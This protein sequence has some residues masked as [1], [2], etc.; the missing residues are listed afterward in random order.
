M[1]HRS[2]DINI[3][4]VSILGDIMDLCSIFML[5]SIATESQWE[6]KNKTLLLIKRLLQI[7]AKPSNLIEPLV[8]HIVKT[9]IPH[10]T[11]KLRDKNRNSNKLFC[12]FSRY[13]KDCLRHSLLNVFVESLEESSNS[14][15]EKGEE[16]KAI[17]TWAHFC[18]DSL[19]KVGKSRGWIAFQLVL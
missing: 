19:P 14:R 7:V 16:I 3:S 13:D 15:R 12:S 18:V 5:R 9:S 4:S 6:R 11:T 17:A 10:F 2:K 1:Q 8:P